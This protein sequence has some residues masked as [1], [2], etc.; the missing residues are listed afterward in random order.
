MAWKKNQRKKGRFFKMFRLQCLLH[1]YIA[2][3]LQNTS[4]LLC[5]KYRG[6]FLLTQISC[7]HLVSEYFPSESS[8]QIWQ[9]SKQQRLSTPIQNRK[10]K[11][12][13]CTIFFQNACFCFGLTI[14]GQWQLVA[15]V[16]AVWLKKLRKDVFLID[17]Q[18]HNLKMM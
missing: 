4:Y 15:L 8:E 11:L 12:K 9:L 1:I 2:R 17:Q 18:F 13:P 5:S 6:L 3:N 16:F 14:T 7:P 10:I